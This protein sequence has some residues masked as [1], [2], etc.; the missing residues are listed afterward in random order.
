MKDED[1]ATRLWRQRKKVICDSYRSGKPVPRIVATRHGVAGTPG[2][3][4]EVDHGTRG[5]H[6]RRWGERRADGV[7]GRVRPDNA[8]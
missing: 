6:D 1:R 8:G 3:E 4:T 2:I 5:S 7:D